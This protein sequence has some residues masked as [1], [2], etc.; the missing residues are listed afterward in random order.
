[1]VI[2]VGISGLSSS[3]S[4][5]STKSYSF[6]ATTVSGLERILADEIKALPEAKK[7]T[8]KKCGVEFTGSLT[9]G[10][11]GLIRLRTSLKLME[12]LVDVKGI[13]SKQDV[14]NLVYD[15]DWSKLMN[16]TNSLKCDV[17]LGAV[18]QALSHSHFT[19][20]TIKNAIIDQFRSSGSTR[21]SVDVVDPDVPILM[22]LHK[23]RAQLYRVW[24]GDISMHKRGYR[25]ISHKAALRET[26][27]AAIILASKWNPREGVL[28]DPMCGSG[29]IAIEAALIAARTAPGLIR[30]AKNTAFDDSNNSNKERLVARTVKDYF[31]PCVMKWNDINNDNNGNRDSINRWDE[32]ITKAMSVDKRMKLMGHGND[33]IIV[34]GNDIHPNAISL[35]RHSAVSAGVDHLIRFACGDISTYCPPKT[36][37]VILTNPPWD[38]R[39]NVDQ[40]S[41]YDNSW[42]KLGE[43]LNKNSAELKHRIQSNLK[44]S[45]VRS[46]VDNESYS[47]Q[48]QALSASIEASV[49]NNKSADG[50]DDHSNAVGWILSGNPLMRKGLNLGFPSAMIEFNAAAV[51]M[52][53]MRFG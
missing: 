51:E 3:V 27:A 30:Y 17:T 6:F 47:Q 9:T 21:P 33:A 28:C 39:L 53:F 32:S 24:S 49:D 16:P 12:K 46:G 26:T 45:F 10:L 29:T 44:S 18:N 1:M 50:D 11:E 43:F 41:D 38:R 2:F 7:I 35:A 37:R 25:E 13:E 31:L 19:A 34:E 20:L 5:S 48:S 40:T 52:Q 8:V 23:D 14:Y 36:P 4:F 15:I 22:Y 42:S